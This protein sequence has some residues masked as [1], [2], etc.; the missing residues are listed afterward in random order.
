[1]IIRTQRG[2]QPLQIPDIFLFEEQVYKRAKITAAVKQV[3]FYAGIL[4]DQ[5]LQGSA[6][7]FSLDIDL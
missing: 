2:F 5:T 6:D 1:L 4:I 3:W 7:G